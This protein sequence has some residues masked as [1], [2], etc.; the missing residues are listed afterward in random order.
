MQSS[1]ALELTGINGVKILAID[2]KDVNSEIFKSRS[3][4]EIEAGEHQIVARFEKVFD[5][6]QELQEVQ[7]RPS[8][9]TID[10]QQNTQISVD[11]FKNEYQASRAIDNE[12]NWNIISKDK[13]YTVE[14][15]DVLIS[16]GFFP[17]GNIEK[18]VATYNQQKLTADSETTETKASNTDTTN[19][20]NVV[21]SMSANGETI[22]TIYNGLS[23]ADKKAFR[24]WL[25][26]QEMK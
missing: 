2:G 11:N 26:E 15:S 9:F 7:S 4:P 10:I 23:S 25:I 8:I 12:L 24:M 22:K 20:A 14:D 6:G 21:A 1:Y 18:V 16:N 13:Q 19:I 17:Y 5:E 3:K